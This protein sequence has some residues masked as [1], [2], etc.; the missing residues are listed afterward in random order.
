MKMKK[1]YGLQMIIDMVH[2]RAR[3]RQ[4]KGN[5]RKVE[6]SKRNEEGMKENFKRIGINQH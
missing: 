6:K 1:N 3:R 4:I 2:C 5:E